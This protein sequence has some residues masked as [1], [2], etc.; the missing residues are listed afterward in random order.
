MRVAPRPS[1]LLKA[2]L[3]PEEESLAIPKIVPTAADAW[4]AIR[5]HHGQSERKPRAGARATWGFG[6]QRA[7]VLLTRASTTRQQTRQRCSLGCPAR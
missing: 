6:M 3:H 5:K 4:A 2:G 1:K 7:C